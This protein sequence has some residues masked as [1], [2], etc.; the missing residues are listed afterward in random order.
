[1]PKMYLLGGENVAKR[2]AKGA[3]EAAFEDAGSR[4]NVLVFPWARASFD[5]AYKRRNRLVDYFRKLGAESV[6]FSDYSDLPEE[7]SDKIVRADLIY[8]T[9]GQVG[10]LAARA[11]CK[12][13]DRLLRDYRG[14]VV[15]RSAGAVVMGQRC[16]V[17]NRY[18]GRRKI[19]DGLGVVDFNVKAHYL[20]S[21]DA[22]LRK[23]SMSGKTYAIPHGSALVYD[24]ENG[25]LTFVGE[26][27]VFVKGE[28][29]LLCEAISDS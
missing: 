29:R 2:D 3:N 19:V 12:G 1:M 28:K 11:I 25:S 23:F 18:S 14:V 24:R 27:F 8:L 17:T 5:S 20:P 13:L 21:Q 26:V 16:L 10:V 22:L 7:I 6:S 4:P 15:G 9:G